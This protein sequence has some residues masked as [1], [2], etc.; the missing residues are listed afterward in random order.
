MEIAHAQIVVAGEKVYV[1]AGSTLDCYNSLKVFEYST[2]NDSWNSL[3]ACLMSCFAMAVFQERLINISG[4]GHASS[5]T[6]KVLSLSR[7]PLQ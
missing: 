5:P 2:T 7:D 6:A 1:E 3:L 4:L